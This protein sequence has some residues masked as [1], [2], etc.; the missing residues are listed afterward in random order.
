MASQRK[1]RAQNKYYSNNAKELNA[2][3]KASYRANPEKKKAASKASY[4]ADPQQRRLP[5]VVVKMLAEY[6]QGSVI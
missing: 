6:C 3:A 1:R 5:P 2:K 4:S